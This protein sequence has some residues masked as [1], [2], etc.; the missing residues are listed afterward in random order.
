MRQQQLRF[1]DPEAILSA[2]EAEMEEIASEEL[3]NNPK[4]QPLL[5][6]WCAGSFAVAYALHLQECG[7]AMEPPE[8]QSDADFHLCTK[9]GVFPFQT[10]EVQRLGRKRGDEY[11]QPPT[12]EPYRPAAEGADGPRWIGAAVQKKVDK[13]YSTA[14]QINLLV[15]ADFT[16]EQL[17]WA[18]VAHELERFRDK[19]A[20]LWVI[21]YSALGTVFSTPELGC[22]GSC[23]K[24]G[25]YRSAPSAPAFVFRRKSRDT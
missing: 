13:R 11:R 16:T 10:T 18:S 19:F 20:S 4:H 7:V 2:V 15:Y 8:A 6:R 25:V 14:R 17:D 23:A 3:F 1:V 22:V 12:L 21:T 24:W 9:V 5:D